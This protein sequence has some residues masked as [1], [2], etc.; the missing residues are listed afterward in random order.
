M[1][2]IILHENRMCV[3]NE[4]RYKLKE[5][6]SSIIYHFAAVPTIYDILKSGNIELT[7]STNTAD[8]YHKKNLFYLSTQRTKSSNMG[9]ASNLSSHGKRSI[10]RIELDGD[11]LKQ[12]GYQGKPLDYWGANMGKQS[13]IGLHSKRI[14]T[15][16]GETWRPNTQ[17]DN[18]NVLK[19]QQKASN[20]EFE[21]RIFSKKPF[22]PLK[23]VKRIDIL[24]NG[25]NIQ[26]IDKSILELAKLS[27]VNVSY[28]TSEKDFLR[29]TNNTINSLILQSNIES[30]NNEISTFNGNDR[31]NKD[32]V[33][34]LSAALL[35]YDYFGNLKNGNVDNIYGTLFKTLKQFNLAVYYEYCKADLNDK[36]NSIEQEIS[37]ISEILRKLN[38][39]RYRNDLS[40]NIMEYAQ[41]VM[42]HYNV[43]SCNGLIKYFR[44]TPWEDNKQAQGKIQESI[45]CVEISDGGE[46]KITRGDTVLF[47]EYIDKNDFYNSLYRQIDN[48][49]WENQNGGYRKIFHNSKSNESFLKYIQHL[50]HNDNLSLYDGS[51][52]LNK[53][54]NYDKVNMYEM[55]GIYLK[56]IQITKGLYKRLEEKIVW[57]DRESIIQSLF[58]SEDNYWNYIKKNI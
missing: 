21:D 35:Y 37:S 14:T 17:E 10:A 18:E 56:P 24:M 55:F 57:R 45:K 1:K 25:K 19:S 5:G 47:W 3:L 44:N 26:T 6:L 53:I 48:D 20:F 38:T 11:L 46:P 8:A 40:H 42:N 39:S 29:Q 32:I 12:D 7:M 2:R 50:M 52:I 41:Y 33:S 13:D 58:G 15:Q 34:T 16:K 43:N 27:N 4:G 49:E 23:Y 9:Y 22:L 36:L 54:F 28:Y 31:M 51:V 30:E